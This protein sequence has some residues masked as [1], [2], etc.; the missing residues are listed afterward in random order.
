M[1]SFFRSDVSRDSLIVSES[2]KECQKE[3]HKECLCDETKSGYVVK[4]VFFYVS[5]HLGR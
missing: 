2:Q 3:C 4:H 1:F 5:K